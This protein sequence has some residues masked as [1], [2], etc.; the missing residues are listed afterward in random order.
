MSGKE[1]QEADLKEVQKILKDYCEV[2]LKQDNV[3][4]VIWMGKYTE[5]K[6]RPIIITI[7]TRKEERNI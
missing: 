6:K 2:E 7:G 4:Q 3:A 5:G 1:K